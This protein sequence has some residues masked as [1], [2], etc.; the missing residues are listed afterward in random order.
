MKDAGQAARG[1]GRDRRRRRARARSHDDGAGRGRADRASWRRRCRHGFL[2]GAGTVID[3][4][5]ARAVIDAGAQF[6][7]SPVFRRDVIDA[8]HERD[9][10]GRARL[11]H[12]DR[13]PRRAWDAGADIVKVFPA[14]ALGPQLHQGRAR[15]AAAGQADADRRRHARQRR[16]LDPRRRGRGRRRHRRCS[17]RRRSR[18]ATSTSSRTTRARIVASVARRT[19][20]IAQMPRRVVTFGEIMLRLSPPGFERLLQSPRAVATF[21]GGE[22]NVAVSLAQFGLDSHYVTRLP[23]HAIG[24]AAVRALRAEGVRTDHIV[25]GGEPRRHLLRRNRRQPARLDGHL[26]PRALGDQRDGAGRGRLGRRSWRAP[27]GSTSPASRRRSATNGGGGHGGGRS[28]AARAR[29]RA[30]QRR[31]ELPQEAVDRGA[32]AGRSCAR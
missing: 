16:R 28:T 17:T 32:G 30:R 11:L 12:A 6:I 15:A 24:D 26:R 31:P 25:R 3:A 13:D 10:A 22:A 19:G 21:G 2:L 5:T 29:R 20:A 7:V 18:R 1:R 14:T 27:P 8:C 9:V 4:E 23:A